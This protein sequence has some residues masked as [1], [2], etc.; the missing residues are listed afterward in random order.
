MFIKEAGEYEKLYSSDVFE[1]RTEER[2]INRTCIVVSR[3]ASQ[4]ER[5]AGTK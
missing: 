3:K 4:G 1:W 5:L 2:M